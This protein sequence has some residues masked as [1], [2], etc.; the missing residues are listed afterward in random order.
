M[1]REHRRFG[2]VTSLLPSPL[3]VERDGREGVS[4]L[5]LY[6]GEE[7][8][9]LAFGVEGDLIVRRGEEEEGEGEEGGGVAVTSVEKNLMNFNPYCLLLEY[10]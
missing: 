2:V 4:G 3:L 9:C 6:E 8:G 1:S 7:R 10:G 5:F